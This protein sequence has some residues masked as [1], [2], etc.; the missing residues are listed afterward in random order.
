MPSPL[1]NPN[2]I[3]VD[4]PVIAPLVADGGRDG[5]R[6]RQRLHG[7]QLA[8]PDLR[9]VGVPVGDPALTRFCVPNGC[10]LEVPTGD[11]VD[12]MVAIAAG[13]LDEAEVAALL[14]AR[15]QLLDSA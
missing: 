5:V 11:D 3:V 8:A 12:L 13:D 15:L 4:A 1:S 14:S 9:R 10:M 7:E 6:F 2:V